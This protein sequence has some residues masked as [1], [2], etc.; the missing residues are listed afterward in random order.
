MTL[1]D[2]V[3]LVITLH[4]GAAGTDFETEVSDDGMS[5]TLA[6]FWP[7]TMINADLLLRKSL[8]DSENDAKM[9]GLVHA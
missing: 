7:E 2:R 3:S 1:T 9:A 6:L 8:K 5:I 4:C